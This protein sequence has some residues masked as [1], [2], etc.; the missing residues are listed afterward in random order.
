MSYSIPIKLAQSD[1]NSDKISGGA[2]GV[3]LMLCDHLC[4]WGCIFSN[5][6]KNW[7]PTSLTSPANKGILICMHCY[8]CKHDHVTWYYGLLWNGQ[9]F[10]EA[11]INLRVFSVFM[12]MG[13]RGLYNSLCCWAIIRVC[14]TR[15]NG[16]RPKLEHVM[17]ENSAAVPWKAN[18][19]AGNECNQQRCEWRKPAV[20]A[21]NYTLHTFNYMCL[22]GSEHMLKQWALAVT[23]TLHS[24]FAGHGQQLRLAYDNSKQWSLI[25]SHLTGTWRVFDSIEH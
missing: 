19:W 18:V 4:C 11:T 23:P 15:L 8:L 6:H 25:F 16:N 9:P 24:V 1:W 17:E 21:F 10:L 13:L 3:T 5:K 7:N 20:M 14:W 2:S 12:Y 22:P